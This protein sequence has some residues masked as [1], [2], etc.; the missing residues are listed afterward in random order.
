MMSLSVRYLE[1]GYSSEKSVSLFTDLLPDVKFLYHIP[2]GSFFTLGKV[3]HVSFFHNA[4]PKTT[5]MKVFLL[6]LSIKEVDLS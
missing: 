3:Y 1:P 5:Y 6:H 4:L 2:M